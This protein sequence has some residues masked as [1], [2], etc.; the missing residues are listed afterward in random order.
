MTY[1]ADKELNSILADVEPAFFPIEFVYG[2][3]IKEK[4]GE[5][6]TISAEMLYE[7]VKDPQAYEASHGFDIS[8]LKFIIDHDAVKDECLGHFYSIMREIEFHC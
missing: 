5:T 8:T 6:V 2:G 7:V 1:D 3:Q 4:G